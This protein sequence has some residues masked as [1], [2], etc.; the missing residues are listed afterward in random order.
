[1]HHSIGVVNESW[2]KNFL[3][4][5]YELFEEHLDVLKENNYNTISLSELY[6]YLTKNI[7]FNFN[8][9][10]LTF[11]DG[12]L[13]SWVFAYPLL[14]K[15]G[16]KGTIFVNPDC[17][18]TS[19]IPRENLDNVW[20]GKCD[21]SDLKTDGFLSWKELEI[22]A[23][24]GVMDIQSHTMSH[25]WYFSGSAIVDFHHQGD[26]YVWLAWNEK[27]E[28]RHLYISE[29]QSQF[30]PYGYPVYE[31]GRALGVRRYFED[32]GLSAELV[33]FV[34]ENGGTKFFDHDNWRDRLF[35]VA[36]DY[37]KT[38]ILKD[39]FE[40]DAELEE[41]VYYEI[42]GSKEILEKKLNK[43]V[44]FLCWPGGAFTDQCVNIA[45][46]VGYKA[47]TLPSRFKNNPKQDD[48]FWIKRTGAAYRFVWKRK[49][50]RYTP[51]NYFLNSVK[52]SAGKK[53]YIWPLRLQKLKY[54]VCDRFRIKCN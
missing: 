27:P 29:D 34:V 19:T 46:E 12:Y 4:C 14:K 26:E 20:S 8:P 43:R 44:D 13:D 16:F 36:N 40:T 50:I 42:R 53:Y 48:P 33:E 49:F 15:Y 3:T 28:R 10:V 31:Y 7:Q 51:A 39:R 47:V 1:M 9:I 30:V 2:T 35:K 6:N 54:L 24:S 5:P 18:D 23:R 32:Q 22:M 21:V 52:L 41:R 38:H 37:K 25:D 11:D 45:R 17:I